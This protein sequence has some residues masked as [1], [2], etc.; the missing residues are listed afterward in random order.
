L[1]FETRQLTILSSTRME[2]EIA[3]GLAILIALVFVATVDMAF[4]NLSD[5]G[6][7]RLSAES[8]ETARPASAAFLREILENRNRFKFVLSSTIQT[9]LISFTVLVS[10][11]IL[12]FT[13]DVTSV[14]IFGL[15]IALASTV[16]FR[17]LIPRLLIRT[18]NERKL[19]FLLPALRPLYA[20]VAYLSTPFAVLFKPKEVQKIDSSVSPD[21]VDDKSE[22]AADDF[23]ALMEVGEAEGIIEEK[24]RELIESMVEFSL[25]RAGEIMTPRT[26]IV[27]IAVGS[28][29]RAARD[30]II[31]QKYSRLPVYRDS[32]DNIEGVIYVRDLLQAWALAKEDQLIDDI[33]R[34][35]YF[36]P[37]TKSASDLLKSMQ[38]EH[39]Q[40]AI[41][42]DEY[43]GV[44]GI[45]SLE[46]I[47][48]EIVGE[49][50]DEDIEEEEIVE[51]IESE[52]GYWDVLGSTEIDKIER[53]FEIELEN[54]EF[55]TIAGMVTSEAGYIP[56]TGEKLEAHGIAIEVL[57]ADEKR[58]HRL[59]LTRFQNDEMIEKTDAAQDE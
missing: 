24:D 25:T 38:V 18:N 8:E 17:Q 28:T 27:A 44:A 50:E 59:R 52:D 33:L 31:D 2:I 42:I 7:R 30:L 36:V 39:V 29:I 13:Q 16:I 58:I 37:E 35:A 47:V 32:I 41:V 57:D 43:G 20:V 14:L 55:T 10:I 6:L 3:A 34:P 15:L 46:D 40:I 49:I 12:E 9:L 5:L 51:I 23:Q 48:E 11:G 45:V 54:D 26:E 53:L 1:H 4:S 22:D 56:R 19:L 21:G